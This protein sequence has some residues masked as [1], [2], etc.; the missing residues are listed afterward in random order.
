MAIKK[1]AF[2]LYTQE[3]K[4][5]DKKPGNS[6]KKSH[7][8]D[9]VNAEIG[10]QSVHD[11]F[12]T[13]KKDQINIHEDKLNSQ[14]ARKED[15]IS[16]TFSHEID[17]T[18]DNNGLNEPSI[19][20]SKNGNNSSQTVHKRF[21]LDE[22]ETKSII[23]V[24]NS[25][26]NNAQQIGGE[27]KLTPSFSKIIGNQREIVIALY[28]NMRINKSDTTEELT[29]EVISNLTGVNLKSLKNTLFRLTSSGVIIRADQK[30]GRGGWVK[31]QISE[32]II[33]EIQQIDFLTFS[34]IKK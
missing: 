4:L 19:K 21:T 5:P 2:E 28:K 13:D 24:E 32:S 20:K 30:V 9:D 31:Y 25:F 15:P 10:S 26:H 3:R 6:G 14:P 33:S 29:L 8:F 11:R 16:D 22:V 23:N 18:I 1:G 7:F 17:L 12:T 27:K 34:K